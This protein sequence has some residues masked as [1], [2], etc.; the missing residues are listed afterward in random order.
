MKKGSNG[1]VPFRAFEFWYSDLFRISSFEF[2]ALLSLALGPWILALL[3]YAVGAAFSASGA[4]VRRRRRAFFAADH[5]FV[6]V[7]K[8]SG[9]S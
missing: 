8:T 5:S 6:S 9:D 2:R 7:S 4:A 1:V 3:S